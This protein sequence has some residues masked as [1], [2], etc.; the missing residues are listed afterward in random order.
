VKNVLEGADSLSLMFIVLIYRFFDPQSFLL[1][2][3]VAKSLAIFRQ[4][5][6]IPGDTDVLSGSPGLLLRLERS[7]G[8]D[9]Q[10]VFKVFKG[11]S[12]QYEEG[13]EIGSE[14]GI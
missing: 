9:R 1:K 7:Y 8:L 13:K 3:F 14:K 6:A 5:S 2:L 10:K 12:S 4:F 11:V